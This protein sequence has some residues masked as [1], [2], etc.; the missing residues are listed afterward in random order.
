MY[1]NYGG[2]L[3]EPGKIEFTIEFSKHNNYTGGYSKTFT[4]ESGMTMEEWF[5]STYNTE[6]YT[7]TVNA[8]T[9]DGSVTKLYVSGEGASWSLQV[10][11]E[12]VTLDTVIED[13]MNMTAEYEGSR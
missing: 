3:K 8:L 1:K 10:S 13:G 11:S 6:A 2:L 7:Y 4:A 5:N 12:Q 9:Q